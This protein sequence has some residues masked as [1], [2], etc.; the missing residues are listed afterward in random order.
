MKGDKSDQKR[1]EKLFDKITFSIK[2]Q[3][4]ILKLRK[5]FGIPE[6][7]YFSMPEVYG[8]Y[9]PMHEPFYKIQKKFLSDISVFLC[10]QAL[11]NNDWWNKKM[12]EYL[13]SDG[14]FSFLPRTLPSAPFIEVL[15]R[16]F[17]KA[18]FDQGFYTDLRI[19]E[20]VSQRD[21]TGYMKNHWNFVRPT[22]RTGTLTKIRKEK[23]PATNK[24]MVEL[25]TK[26][27]EDLGYK[28]GM[29]TTK[30]ILLSRTLTKENEKDANKAENIGPKLT[31][32][33]IRRTIYRK[34]KSHR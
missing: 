27:K 4:E 8:W 25:W 32:E 14:R 23:N 1:G 2:F 6:T 34:K 20:G 18:G 10:K 12:F 30:E 5:K 9:G 31:P 15:G 28:E 11:P 21:I 33:N 19:Y 29:I 7:G 24:R 26:S 17:L 3:K 16:N 22:I 13:L